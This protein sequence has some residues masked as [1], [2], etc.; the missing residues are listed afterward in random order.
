MKKLFT[1][2]TLS[3]CLM[4]CSNDEP[5]DCDCDRVTEILTPANQHFYGSAIR[6]IT[7]N[8]CSGLP[9]NK[10]IPYHGGTLEVGQCR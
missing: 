8:D 10:T 6:I 4:S 2:A 7:V 9:L 1:L 3:L 5:K